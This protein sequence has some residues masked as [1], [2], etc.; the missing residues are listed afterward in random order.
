[1]NVDQGNGGI[2]RDVSEAGVAIQ[3]VARLHPNQQV[4]LRFDLLSP[5][6]RIEATGCVAWA[7]SKGQAG[8]AF[9]ALPQ[10]SRRLLRDW[11]FAQAL[12]TAEYI[13]QN[14]IFAQ[15]EPSERAAELS[16]SSTDRAP[17]RLGPGA[18]AATVAAE[19]V[20]LPPL[21][22]SW[23]PFL[24]PRYL[25]SRGADAVIIFLAVLL[26][27]V[28]AGAIARWFPA[29]PAAFGL[30]VAVSAIFAC[31]YWYLFRVW[32]GATPGVEFTRL[33]TRYCQTREIA[34]EDPPRFR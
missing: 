22:L 21:K 25:F 10:R 20:A 18:V 16:F 33:V 12:I 34:E 9:R 28:L 4:F 30:A 31:L 27:S 3:A 14:S 7:D 5:R 32:I 29:G 13:S 26:F 15:N 23:F 17:I 2:I 19:K 11:I 8:I 24:I 1:V 6:L